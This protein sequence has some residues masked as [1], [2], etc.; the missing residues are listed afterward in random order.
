MDMV[1]PFVEVVIY[2]TTKDAQTRLANE[3][4]GIASEKVRAFPGFLR[5]LVLASEDGATVVAITQW[6]DRDCFLGFR[7]SEFGGAAI[8]LAAGLHP[9]AHWLRQHAAVEAP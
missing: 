9:Q 6:S 1:E 7:Q 4:V 8:R 3:L 2:P 5:A